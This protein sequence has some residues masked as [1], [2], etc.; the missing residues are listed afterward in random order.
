MTL[1][2]CILKGWRGANE[3][4]TFVELGQACLKASLACFGMLFRAQGCINFD[5]CMR[6]IEKR[7]QQ[8]ILLMTL[9]GLSLGFV[10]KSLEVEIAIIAMLI[11]QN[12]SKA[13]RL[14][15]LIDKESSSGPS[16]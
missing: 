3:K 6:P 15:L 14:N 5:L 10:A 12:A 9:S 7:L 1:V 11:L 8:M 4:L 2:P 13:G 16:S